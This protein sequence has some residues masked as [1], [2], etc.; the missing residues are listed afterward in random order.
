M[1]VLLIAIEHPGCYYMVRIQC[2]EECFRDHKEQL[3]QLIKSIRIMNDPE[4]FRYYA[5]FYPI[6]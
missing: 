5:K 4:G 6:T 2:P 1:K 3:D